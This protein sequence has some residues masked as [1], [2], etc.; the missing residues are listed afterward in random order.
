MVSGHL[1]VMLLCR[2]LIPRCMEGEEAKGNVYVLCVGAQITWRGTVQRRSQRKVKGNL[3]KPPHLPSAFVEGAQSD[4]PDQSKISDQT[5][6]LFDF[7]YSDSRGVR[8]V[9]VNDTSSKSQYIKL[10]VAGI[11]TLGIIDTGSDITIMGG[12]LFKKVAA[13]ARLRKRDFKA[14]DKSLRGYDGSPFHLDG[15]INLELSVGDRSMKT[16]VYVRMNARNQLLLSEGVCRQLQ[17][18]KYHPDAI[19]VSPGKPP[20]KNVT[21][22]CHVDVELVK[23][24]K[25]PPRSSIIA[26]IHVNGIDGDVLLE[27]TAACKAVIEGSL[28]HPVEG[29]SQIVRL[30]E[31]SIDTEDAPP[32]RHPLRQTPFAAKQEI[33]HQLQRMQSAGVIQPSNSPWA[34]PVILVNKR[35]NTYRF[36]VDYRSLNS[37]TKSD[38]FPLP[39]VDASQSVSRH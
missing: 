22:P 4:T 5:D 29:M 24:V 10:V 35:D 6:N 18:A 9:C 12:E 13:V 8:M 11:P 26:P 1:L 14:A 38:A 32:V 17:I 31:F 15:R 33:A 23:S 36:C 28:I 3:A 2:L 20:P 30:I 21:P 34:S 16:P 7:L 25:V 19:S 39:R 37:V 27:P